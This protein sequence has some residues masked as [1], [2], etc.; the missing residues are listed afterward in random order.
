MQFTTFLEQHCLSPHAHSVDR[1]DDH[2]Q[3]PQPL[4]I[5]IYLYFCMSN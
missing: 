5:T 2:V 1:G 3:V 4:L